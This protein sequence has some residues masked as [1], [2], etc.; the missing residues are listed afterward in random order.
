MLSEKDI[1][2]HPDYI[3]NVIRI[4]IP[5]VF[6][7]FNF[8]TGLMLELFFWPDH[9]NSY[10]FLVFMIKT[11]D[12]LTKAASPQNLN[13]FKSI[14]QVIMLYY[15]VISIFIIISIIVLF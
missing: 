12:S 7:N 2:L 6:Q 5:Q 15:I 1:F 4:I 10:E 14:G 11:F 13:N 8:Y 9:F 3:S